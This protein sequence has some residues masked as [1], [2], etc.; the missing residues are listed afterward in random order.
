MAIGAYDNM[1]TYFPGQP[2]NG[3][4]VRA[5][6]VTTRPDFPD[7]TDVQENPG[8]DGLPYFHELFIFHAPSAEIS[9]E[10]PE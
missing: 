10:C 3:F 4:A 5:F 6:A 7:N 1:F 9:R 2:D 8:L